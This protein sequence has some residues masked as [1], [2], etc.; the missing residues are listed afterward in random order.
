MSCV[1]GGRAVVGASTN[2]INDSGL[3]VYKHGP[4]HVL[5]SIGLTEGRV[6]EVVSSHN[7]LVAWYL[8]IRLDAVFRA[9][10]LPGVIADLETPA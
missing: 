1:W 9:E 2:F 10:D 4:G 5:S 6:E 8:A 7:G 3:Q